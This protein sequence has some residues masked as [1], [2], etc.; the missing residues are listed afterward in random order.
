MWGGA[1]LG[2]WGSVLGGGTAAGP[3]HTHT[4]SAHRLLP[5]LCSLLAA[6]RGRLVDV[7]SRGE[8]VAGTIPGAL[9]IP[10][11]GLGG[12]ARS[13]RA[14]GALAE[15]QATGGFADFQR[16]WAMSCP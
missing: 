1:V 4:C 11:T 10:R 14:Q 15:L 8:A 2:W 13:W 12:G 16:G 7:R 9:S 6:G 5:E 3:P